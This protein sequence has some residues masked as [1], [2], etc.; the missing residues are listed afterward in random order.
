MN[1]EFDSEPVY[2]GND[3]NIKTKLKP[4][5]DKVNVNFQDKKVP[6]PPPAPLKKK[7]IIQVCVIDNA[8][9]FN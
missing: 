6:V 8:R 5:G 2:G 9:F 4:Y 7:C 1:I 3:K